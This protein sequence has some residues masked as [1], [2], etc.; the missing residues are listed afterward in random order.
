VAL[1]SLF[2]VVNQFSTQFLHLN[3]KGSE[4]GREGKGEGGTRGG[5]EGEGREVEELMVSQACS[6]DTTNRHLQRQ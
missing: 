6:D 3:K 1:H 4:K 5:R 2:N